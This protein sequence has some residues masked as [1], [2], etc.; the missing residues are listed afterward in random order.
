[1]SERLCNLFEVCETPE[2]PLC[3]IQE[4][5]LKHAIWYPGEP[6]CQSKQFRDLPWIKKQKQIAALKLKADVGF[7]TVRMLDSIHVVTKN[8]K[9]AD[10]DDPSAELKW[11]KKRDEKRVAN[12]KKRKRRKGTRRKKPAAPVL[13]K[14]KAPKAK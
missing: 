6:I 2:A 14:L 7:F 11:L 12:S 3:P 8:I 9:G 1:M 13:F 5:A 4:T 10:P